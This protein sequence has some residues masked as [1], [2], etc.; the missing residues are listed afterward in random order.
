MAPSN[1]P[2]FLSHV[3]LCYPDA[4]PLGFAGLRPQGLRFSEA[5]RVTALGL[6]PL[7]LATSQPSVKDTFGHSQPAGPL[8][9]LHLQTL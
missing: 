6:R 4:D 1:V 7:A 2:V 5:A 3:D 8:L 9:W